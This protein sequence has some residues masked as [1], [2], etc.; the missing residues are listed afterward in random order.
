[1]LLH[2]DPKLLVF[3]S[4]SKHQKMS[5]PRS[6]SPRYK[7]RSISPSFRRSPE[8]YVERPFVKHYGDDFEDCKKGPGKHEQ[9]KGPKDKDFRQGSSRV[10]QQDDT[11]QKYFDHRPP[12]PDARRTQSEGFHGPTTHRRPPS[13]EPF[14][15]PTTQRRYPSPEQERVRGR[16]APPPVY[17]SPGQERD[18]G[19]P[20]PPRYPEEGPPREYE[21][22]RFQEHRLARSKSPRR[23]INRGKPFSRPARG[24][25]WQEGKDFAREERYSVSPPR[26][27]FEEYHRRSPYEER[28][29][30]QAVQP[31]YPAERGFR[32]HSRSAERARDTERCEER[33]PRRSPKWKPDRSSAPY[34]KEGPGDFAHGRHVPYCEDKSPAMVA[35]EYGHKHQRETSQDK[36]VKPRSFP[37]REGGGYVVPS[38]SDGGNGFRSGKMRLPGDPESRVSPMHHAEDGRF[39][40]GKTRPAVDRERKAS[41]TRRG[42]T[43]KFN[44]NPV[45][46]VHKKDVDLRPPLPE[47]ERRE[48]KFSDFNSLNMHRR[49]DLQEKTFRQ[50]DLKS[51]GPQKP[52]VPSDSH[53]SS[54][55]ET[56]TIKVDMKRSMTKCSPA[57]HSTDRQLC[58][59]LVAVSRKGSEFH[60]VLKHTGSSG[61]ALR[62]PQTG[63]F[64]QDI[65]TLVHQVKESYFKSNEGLTLNDRFSN[66]HDARTAMPEG[67]KQHSGPEINRR[68]DLSLS[69]LQKNRMNKRIGPLQTCSRVIDDPNDLRH[70]IERRR[71]ERQLDIDERVPDHR[72]FSGRNQNGAGFTRR[73]QEENFFPE[74][75]QFELSPERYSD[76]SPVLGG[77][78][79]E[80]PTTKPPF[81]RKKPFEGNPG[82]FRPIRGSLRGNR[83]P[84]QQKPGFVQAGLSI[85]SKYRRLQSIRQN[86]PGYRGIGYRINR[87]EM[88]PIG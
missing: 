38:Q 30:N 59:D 85:Q 31:G 42:N 46:K 26:R 27:G 33:E 86:G 36:Y 71:K 74:P 54:R 43:K 48:R 77:F 21:R 25:N 65:I 39:N 24:E 2:G 34:P 57:R 58:Q 32:K 35:F 12:G 72:H 84:H 82:S 1:M 81:V 88:G 56:L 67:G 69:D 8:C 61:R 83:L 22:I 6:R 51:P 62:S 11:R 37:S 9:W 78:H 17:P 15:G 13:P 70:D 29:R 87:S 18:R 60:S 41:P 3:C 66:I 40:S 7:Y 49:T 16:P 75:N 5:R 19:R 50:G 10:S 23:E 14:R 68:I 4:A 76:R 55:G 45:H 80:G 47:Q 53:E 64:A 52:Y 73:I 79:P 44:D 28:N 63:G 20:A